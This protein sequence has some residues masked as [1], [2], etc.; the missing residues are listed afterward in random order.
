MWAILSDRENPRDEGGAGHREAGGNPPSVGL[1]SEFSGAALFAGFCEGCGASPGSSLPV[2][3][4]E[5]ESAQLEPEVDR[6]TGN[7]GR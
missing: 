2:A 6:D 3:S 4:P 5:M 1:A 7:G